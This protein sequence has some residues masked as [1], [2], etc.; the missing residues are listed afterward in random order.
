MGP[1]EHWGYEKAI[2][3]IKK[4]KAKDGKTLVAFE[5]VFVNI[6]KFPLE[7]HSTSGEV[8]ARAAKLWLLAEFIV[9]QKNLHTYCSPLIAKFKTLKQNERLIL[10]RKFQIS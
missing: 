9:K 6:L 8:W 4:V 5:T 2:E 10:Q 7:S 1:K 3:G